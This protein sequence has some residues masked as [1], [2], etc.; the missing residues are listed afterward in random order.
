MKQLL[1]LIALVLIVI[2]CN[3][4]IEYTPSGFKPHVK[5]KPLAFTTL[6]TSLEPSDDV[7]VRDRTYSDIN[8]GSDTNLWIKGTRYANYKR[9]AY[10]KFNLAGVSSVTS[11]KLRV[12]GSNISA[13]H[14]VPVPVSAYLADTDD[15]SESVVTYNTRPRRSGVLSTVDVDTTRQYWEWDVTAAVI[16]QVS[17][18][19]VVSFVLKD[20]TFMDAECRFLSKEAGINK[21]ELVIS[22]AVE[23]DTVVIR[24]KPDHQIFIWFENKSFSQIVG[25]DNAPYMNSLIPQGTI[26]DCL[27]PLANLPSQPQY[28][29]FFSGSQNTVLNN[30]CRDRTFTTNNLFT[31]LNHFGK[32]FAWYSE[33]LPFEGSTACSTADEL[34][35]SKHNPVVGWVEANSPPFI[36]KPFSALNLTDTA[37]FR[38]FPNVVCITPNMTSD[39][40]DGPTTEQCIRNGDTWLKANFETL[41][42][43]AMQ[44]GSNTEVYIYWD[45]EG[46]SAD[47]RIPVIVLGEHI[48]KGFHSK[49]EYP[50]G[51]FSIVKM[52]ST[53]QGADTT[54]TYFGT[55]VFEAKNIRDHRIGY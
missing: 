47:P 22:S 13:K 8:Y 12:Y 34:Y 45:E 40:H 19:G 52:I 25:S 38:K 10:I 11:A 4:E 3:K 17:T 18:D 7:F 50:S 24:D 37:E 31:N 46:S 54:N 9:N 15:W 16:S 42:N 39:M 41:I 51:H 26:F 2:A 14:P 20:S 55:D 29:A 30:S 43:W 23:E 53:S 28:Y 1:L 49:V 5:M 32:T 35:R 48:K 33:N 44:P 27:Y 6:S 36:N 21:P